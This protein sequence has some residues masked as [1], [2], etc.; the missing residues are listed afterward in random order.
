MHQVAHAVDGEGFWDR[1]VMETTLTRDVLEGF[2]DDYVR[3]DRRKLVGISSSGAREML[4]N[5]LLWFDLGDGKPILTV[6]VVAVRG[7]RLVLARLHVGYRDG[8]ATGVLSVTQ[9][10]EAVEKTQ[11]AVRFDPDDLDAALAE[12]DKLHTELEARNA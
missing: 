6:E 12:L 1:A 7:D 11:R 3:E 4:E 2:T 9:F 10:D 5:A 8:D